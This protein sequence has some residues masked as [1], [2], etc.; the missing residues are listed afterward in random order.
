MLNRQETCL[1]TVKYLHDKNKSLGIGLG[2]SGLGKLALKNWKLGNHW[3]ML[4]GPK[5]TQNIVLTHNGM[6]E[7]FVEF[8]KDRLAFWKSLKLMFQLNLSYSMLKI[9]VKR[10]GIFVKKLGIFFF[11]FFFFCIGN[12][13]IFALQIKLRKSTV[14]L[15]RTKQNICLIPVTWLFWLIWRCVKTFIKICCSLFPVQILEI[16]QA[17][18]FKKKTALY[19]YLCLFY[20]KSIL[21]VLFLKLHIVKAKSPVRFHCI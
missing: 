7:W 11:F 13:V 18:C 8:E 16:F 5:N 3:S 1:K 9:F 19:T 15:E 17:S 14:S 10:M 4:K 6:L 12:G 2:S 20:I 21:R